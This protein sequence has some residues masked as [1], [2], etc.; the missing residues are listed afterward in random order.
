MEGIIHPKLKKRSIQMGIDL[1]PLGFSGGV[2]FWVFFVIL[3]LLMPFFVLI[4]TFTLGRI[5]GELQKLN[6]HHNLLEERRR[7]KAL[8]RQP[9]GNNEL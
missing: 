6:K 3:G 9:L 8:G 2:L 7:Q 5:L 1:L 4:N